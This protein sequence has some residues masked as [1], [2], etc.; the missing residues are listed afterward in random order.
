LAAASGISA[1]AS[2]PNAVVQVQAGMNVQPVVLVDQN[3]NYVT[4]AGSVMT[5]LGDMIYENATPAPARLAGNA[6]ATKK[7]LTQTGTGAI[8]AAPG[9]GVIAAGDLP[10]LDQVPAPVAS[11]SLNSQKITSLANGSATT[12]AAAYG[13]VLGAEPSWLPADAGFLAWTYDPGAGAT[14]TFTM[15]SGTVYLYRINVR[16]SLTCTNVLVIIGTAGSGLTSNQNFAGLYRSDGT[17]VG[18]TADQ[19]TPWATAGLQTMA[20]AGGPFAL[21]AGFYW[22]AMMSVGTTPPIV[23]SASGTFRASNA[24]TAVS[25]ARYATNGTGQT[26]LPASITPGSNS[27]LSPAVWAALS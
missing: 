11:V 27:L 24:G 21:T 20:L 1:T 4:T 25:V 9:W 14:G 22:V 13:Q 5:T 7:F 23:L 8:S 3:G 17:R 12:D 6:T 2:P 26:A 15:V 18:I 19:T 10:T 16:A